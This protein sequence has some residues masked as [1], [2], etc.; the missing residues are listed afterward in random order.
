VIQN[1]EQ[2][3]RTREALADL[4]ASMASL[5]RR[6]GSIH[7]DRFAMMAGPI[8]EHIQR[9][10]AEIEAYIGM[11]DALLT[12]ARSGSACEVPPSS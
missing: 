8:V 4:E 9:L 6:K 12:E 7:P 1:D 3:T 11:T 10:R 5:N 2:L